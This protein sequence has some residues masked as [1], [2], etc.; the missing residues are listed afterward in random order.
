MG[1]GYSNHD[2]FMLN[3]FYIIK[4]NVSSSSTYIVDSCDIWH[5]RS[6]YVNFS[7]I[8]KMV[9]LSLIPKVSLENYGKCETCV[10]SKTTKKSCKSIERVLELL[11]L[12]H[13]DLGDLKSTMNR[14]GT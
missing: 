3:V 2:L 12:I 11:N 10:E 1:K 5:G 14:G 6:G 13:N 7:Y 9:E 4:D 8:K